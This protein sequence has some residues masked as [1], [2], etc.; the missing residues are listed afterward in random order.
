MLLV[1]LAGA[2]TAIL[3]AIPRY[4]PEFTHDDDNEDFGK[5]EAEDEEEVKIYDNIWVWKIMLLVIMLVSSVAGG[6]YVMST[7]CSEAIYPQPI[8]KTKV[9]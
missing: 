3:L 5:E 4:P 8:K 2:I 6:V 7:H 1:S 9:Q